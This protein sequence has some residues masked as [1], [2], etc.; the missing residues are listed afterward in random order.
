[1]YD[2]DLP[3]VPTSETDDRFPS[4][5]WVGYFIQ[6]NSRSRTELDLFFKDGLI[7]GAGADWVG[8]FIVKGRYQIDDGKCWWTKRYLKGHDVA[9]QGYAEGKGIWGLWEIPQIAGRGGFHIWPKGSPEGDAVE[10]EEAEPVTTVVF[11]TV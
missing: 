10:A 7:S 6:W 3:D 8:E 5:T 1:M 4:G 2:D 11:E 9:Y